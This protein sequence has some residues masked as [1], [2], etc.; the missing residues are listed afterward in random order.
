MYIVVYTRR[1]K[2]ACL[3]KADGCWRALR[4]D[5]RDYELLDVDPPPKESYSRTCR[6]CWPVTPTG[7]ASERAAPSLDS[8]SASTDSSES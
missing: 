5:F 3:H 6:D 4:R 8:Q 7:P 2:E 1:R